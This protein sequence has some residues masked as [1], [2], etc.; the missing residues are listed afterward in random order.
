M[1]EPSLNKVTYLHTLFSVV[2][3]TIPQILDHPLDVIAV[4]N[5]NAELRCRAIGSPKPK[6]HWLRDG[7]KVPTDADDPEQ[8][9]FIM[10]SG[11]LT[12]IRVIQK[13]KKTDTGKYQCVAE[14][15]AGKTTSREA[16]LFVGGKMLLRLSYDINV[17][18]NTNYLLI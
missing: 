1:F 10:P 17:T 7:V 9:R 5:S 15:R 4:K 13:K 11:N 12:F 8:R 3:D 16:E 14:N 2:V 6:I 18:I